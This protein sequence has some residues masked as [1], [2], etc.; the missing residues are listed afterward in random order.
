MPTIPTSNRQIL[1]RRRPIGPLQEGDLELVERDLQAPGPGQVL[2][3]NRY[4]SI[5]PAIR[6]WMGA[7][8]S[9]MDPIPL[10]DVVR[11]AS[12]SEVVQSNRPDYREGELVVGLT[13]WEEYSLVGDS[14]V[15][16]KIPP[17]LPL[18]PSSTLGLLGGSGLTAY[19]GLLEVGAAKAGDV[20]LVSAAAGSVGSIV[21]QLA[22]LK[23]CH[24]VGIVGSEAK[25]RWIVDALGFDSAINR[26]DG[27]IDRDLRAACPRGIDLY[28]DNVG[29]PI[30]DVA[31]RHIRIGARV[32]L[33]GAISQIESTN[34][35]PGPPNYIRLLTRRARMEGFI[36]L[37]FAER[38]EEAAAQ[39]TQWALSGQLHHQEQVMRGLDSAPK[40]LIGLLNGDNIG[41]VIVKV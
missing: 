5:D 22:K 28:F 23:G 21:G 25:C 31:L 11:S 15:G 20:V 4:L 33:C 39:L 35:P 19:F 8:A 18:P 3:R 7:G 30:L 32:V 38:W 40:A 12:V 16:R 2:L 13:G 10:N 6:G 24:V 26:R 37:D 41:K 9:Y 29:G 34:L 1:L 17:N 27:A 14:F 36:T